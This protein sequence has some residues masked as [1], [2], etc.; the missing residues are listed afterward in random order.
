MNCEGLE[1]KKMIKLLLDLYE[2][3]ARCVFGT[4]CHNLADRKP[5]FDKLNELFEKEKI[6]LGPLGLQS[7][8]TAYI[9]NALAHSEKKVFSDNFFNGLI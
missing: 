7:A 9:A 5:D 3:G 2:S 1:D 6:K 8:P 4:D